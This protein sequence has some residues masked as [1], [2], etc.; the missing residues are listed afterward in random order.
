MEV[1][2]LAAIDDFPCSQQ[3]T[4]SESSVTFAGIL[5][6]RHLGRGDVVLVHC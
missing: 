2:S 5:G 1:A 3:Q 4:G 6:W